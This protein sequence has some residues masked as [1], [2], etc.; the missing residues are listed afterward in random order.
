[1]DMPS[2]SVSIDIA[3]ATAMPGNRIA[4][5]LEGQTTLV[6]DRVELRSLATEVEC[7]GVNAS[8]EHPSPH[9]PRS[10]TFDL[11]LHTDAH[12][13]SSVT[14]HARGEGTYV[15]PNRPEEPLDVRGHTSRTIPVTHDLP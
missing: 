2:L 7:E 4:V 8:F 15:R 13:P 10:W 9:F 11:M 14:I 12:P 6:G 3:T 5:S 1:M